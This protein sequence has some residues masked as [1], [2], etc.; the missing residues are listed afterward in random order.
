VPSYN[1]EAAI[2]ETLDSLL[3]QRPGLGGVDAVYLADDRSTDRTVDVAQCM[4]R[5]PVPLQVIQPPRNLGTYGNTNYVI[6]QLADRHDW[7]LILH[8][9]DLA[10][11]DWVG[12]TGE[13]IARSGPGVAS[14]CSSYDVLYGDGRTEPGEDNP[15]RAVEIVAGSADA[16]RSTVQRG[17]WWHIS[18][19][20][21]RTAAFR[22][23]GRF[24]TSLPQSSD[25]DWVIRCLQQG[26]SIAYI[27]RT[28]IGYRQHTGTVSSR[29]FQV[30]RDLEE[31]LILFDRYRAFITAGD[32]VRL[33]AR[34]VSFAARRGVRAALQGRGR[35][36]RGAM[37]VS[38]T[39][40]GQ[41]ARLLVRA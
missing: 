15:A 7:L 37:A 5:A 22:A 16:V 27:P 32:V 23:I 12:R 8:D 19:C 36:L 17:C 30:H 33:H 10:R 18:G 9:D 35:R 31:Q 13:E 2:A 38:A 41:A 11:E 1:R 4:W 40:V 14:I 26:W 39:A 3:Q 29:S 21:I 34:L 6:E 28:L 24:D 20:A 25:W